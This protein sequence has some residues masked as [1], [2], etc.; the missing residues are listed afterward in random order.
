MPGIA[1]ALQPR[2]DQAVALAAI[3]REL[4]AGDRTQLIW[5]SG[6]GKTLTGRW[7]AEKSGAQLVVVFLPSLALVAQTLA[8]WRRASDRSWPFT[9]QVICSVPS[10]VESAAERAEDL[11]SAMPRLFWH[12]V[13]ATITT[14]QAWRQTISRQLLLV[15]RICTK[16]HG[17]ESPGSAGG[18]SHLRL[19]S[20]PR[21]NGQRRAGSWSPPDAAAPSMP[22]W[23]T[24]STR[25]ARRAG[26][27]I[28]PPACRRATTSRAAAS[29]EARSGYAVRR[30]RR[31]RPG[32]EAASEEYCSHA[33]SGSS[34]RRRCRNRELLSYSPVPAMTAAAATKRRE[35]RCLTLSMIPPPTGA[36]VRRRAMF[37]AATACSLMP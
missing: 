31:L 34:G 29:P 16:R 30:S 32:S 22:R 33:D 21:R 36:R 1:A 35:R 17:V 10:T 3:D 26:R 11:G 13:S 25:P 24:T 2:R 27:P 5:A 15:W 23:W 18:P 19:A 8:E 20:S 12:Q 9:A 28:R 14:R 37:A 6:T 4:A 7:Y